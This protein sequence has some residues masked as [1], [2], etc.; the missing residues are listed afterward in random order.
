MDNIS[1]NERNALNALKRN[2][3][4]NLI[5]ADKGTTT[6]ILDNAQKLDEGLQQVTI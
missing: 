5:K 4:I 6:V 2:S 1:A 3:K